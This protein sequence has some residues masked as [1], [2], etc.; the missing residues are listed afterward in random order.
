MDINITS[1][2][3]IQVAKF[4]MKAFFR[5]SFRFYCLGLII[6]I[7]AFSLSAQAANYNFIVQPVLPADQIRK[8]Y[9]PL[10]D[11]LSQQTGHT[12]SVKAYRDFMVYWI[13]MQKAKDM[14]FVLDAAHFTDYRVKRKGYRVLAKFP[15]T[16]S[17]TVVTGE[18]SFILD[19]EELIGKRIATMPSPGMGAVRLNQMFPNPVRL[20]V[21]IQ[22]KNSVEAV[23][24]VLAGGVDAAIIPSP[25][26]GAYDQLNTVESTESVP[27]MAVSAS[28]EV[29]EEVVQAVKKALLEASETPRGRKMLEA[30]N[31]EGFENATAQ[32]YGGYAELLDGVFGY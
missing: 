3:G 24:K 12:F 1:Y 19:M 29:P 30:M 22:V 27:H 7:N 13:R 5:T 10:V 17:F 16:V 32:T 4:I 18:D 23:D 2:F 21:F 8:N 20:P 9:Q 25:L 15:D 26:V 6:V 28:S 31:L 14:H 11:Y